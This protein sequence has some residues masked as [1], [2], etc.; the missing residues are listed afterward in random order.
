MGASGKHL[1]LVQ[2]HYPKNL[3]ALLAFYQK[4]PRSLICAGG[5][6]LLQSPVWNAP[7]ETIQDV[8]SLSQ[9]P[10]LTHISRTESYI[11]V[12]AAAPISQILGIGR[13]VLSA[14]LESALTRVANGAVRNLATLGGSLAFSDRWLSLVP[15]LL[16]LDVRLEL[17]RQSGGEWVPI[18]KFLERHPLFRPGEM[19]TRIR[20]PLEEWNVQHFQIY[21]SHAFGP[22]NQ[23]SWCALAQAEKGYL[24]RFRMA[25]GAPA[26]LIIRNRELENTVSGKKLPLSLKELAP[27]QEQ[28]QQ[29]LEN[30][31]P[32][33]SF[34]QKQLMT[35]TTY[36]FLL[37]YLTD[38]WEDLP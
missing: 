9:I 2:V 11:E 30:V 32:R 38:L 3:P 10:E 34:I 1:S 29:T 18:A 24:E 17:R 31:Q 22:L 13:H 8:I 20:I 16:L 26:G 12:G 33:L 5:T 28:L 19:L 7:K 6:S 37:R 14:A 15:V 4:N 35:R 27:L 36:W 21:K 25:V 23:L